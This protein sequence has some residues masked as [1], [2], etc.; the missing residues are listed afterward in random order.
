ME[1]M[2]NIVQVAVDA[3]HGNVAKYSVNQSMDLLREAAVELNGGSTKLNY[4][5]IRDGKCNG[6]F[7]LIEEILSRTVSEG[8]QSTDFF[9]NLVEYR[10]VAEGDQNVF[11]VEDTDLYTVSEVANG[12]QAIRRQRLGGYNEVTI[13]TSVKAVKIYEEL[14]RVLAGQVD[15]N[16]MITKVSESFQ[17]KLLSDCYAAWSTATAADIGGTAFFPVAGPYDEDTLLETIAHVEAAAG[18][19]TATILGTKLGLRKLMP[20]INGEA[21]KTAMYNDGYAG[22]FY[23]SPVMV[24]PQRHKIGST[25]FVF[26]DNVITIIAGDDRPI[27]CVREGN[28]TIIMGQPTDNQDLTQ[29]YLYMEKYG[30]GLVLAGGNAG[31]GRYQIA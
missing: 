27:K 10:N 20:S 17:Q 23:G 3:Y 9:N 4:K 11:Y 22:R 24:M 31:I 28:S 12:T 16:K 1:D 8:L 30:I 25:D 2:K 6:L 18:G 13:P 19:K 26:D 15:F 21:Y 7:S 5:A 29:S 14:N